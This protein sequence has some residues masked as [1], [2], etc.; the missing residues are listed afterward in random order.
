MLAARSSILSILVLL[1]SLTIGS[2]ALAQ[3]KKANLDKV[4]SKIGFTAA[5]LLFDVDGEFT[6]FDVMLDG[7]HN[8]ISDAK[9]KVEI[10]ASSVFTANRKRDQHL[11]N[12]DFFNVKKHPKLT[13]TS[14]KIE[15]KGDKVHVTGDL[16]ILGNKKAVTIPFDVV[17]GKNGQGK[18]TV[19][20][21][22]STT[23][24]RTEF[25]VGAESVAA[26]IGLKDEVDL[27][28]LVVAMP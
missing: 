28:L 20:Y 3:S 22:G 24:D 4:H 18:D 6:K 15:K 23:I 10:D 8:N 16:E 7:N 21:K 26:N 27:N 5:T 14:K 11:K 17:K 9:L 13:F 25:G 12:E 2:S 19:A 1:L